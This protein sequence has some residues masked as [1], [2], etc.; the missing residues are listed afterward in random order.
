VILL[1]GGAAIA[2]ATERWPVQVLDAAALLAAAVLSSALTV[3]VLRR[4]EIR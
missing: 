3:Y 2:L 4:R 1:A